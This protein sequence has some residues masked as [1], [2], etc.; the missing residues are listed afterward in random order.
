MHIY[1]IF[2][3]KYL[4]NLY[5]DFQLTRKIFWGVNWTHNVECTHGNS[6][7]Y[8]FTLEFKILLDKLLFLCI[9]PKFEN[10]GSTTLETFP[11]S[12]NFSSFVDFM[13]EVYQNYK[14]DLHKVRSKHFIYICDRVPRKST[15]GTN[16]VLRKRPL[17]HLLTK[18]LT[19]FFWELDLWNW[20]PFID[21]VTYIV[22]LESSQNNFFYHI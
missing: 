13:M 22:C 8:S 9:K 1:W 3:T 20:S 16:N 11:M 12:K 21:I 15:G 17:K 14:Y 5:K 19:V 18:I 4:Q 2:V 6:R 7:K 10:F